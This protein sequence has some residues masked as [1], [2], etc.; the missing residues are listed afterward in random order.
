[1]KRTLALT[2]LLVLSLPMLAQQAPRPVQLPTS[3]QPKTAEAPKPAPVLTLLE[4]VKLEN[5]QLKFYLLQQ[6]Q[7]DLQNQ[8]QALVQGIVA[9]HPGFTWNP[10]TSSLQPI[11]AP[12]KK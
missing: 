9:E 6:Q 7:T 10:Q 4:K 1:M 12:E 3:A 11:P 5:L 2:V 8:Y